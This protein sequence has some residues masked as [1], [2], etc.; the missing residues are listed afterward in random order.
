M[1]LYV[2]MCPPSD[3]LTPP[4]FSWHWW[5][6]VM[7]IAGA[8]SM[9]VLMVVYVAKLRRKE[10][11]FGCVGSF[12][13]R[14]WKGGTVLLFQTEAFFSV[15]WPSR[16]I[17]EGILEQR[18]VDERSELINCHILLVYAL[19]GR[20]LSPWWRA[21]SLWSGTAPVEPTAAEQQKRRVSLPFCP[22]RPAQNNGISNMCA[23]LSLQQWEMCLS[24][25]SNLPLSG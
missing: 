24:A 3:L 21:E 15:P 16:F 17:Y 4:A 10:T 23:Q 9:A 19:T 13:P 7:A 8:V 6:V 12:A 14:G 25:C 20:R 22:L 5:Y 18:I 11:R 1:N 2:R